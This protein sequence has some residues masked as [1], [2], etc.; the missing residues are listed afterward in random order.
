[1]HI[2]EIVSFLPP[3]GGYFAI[4]QAAALQ[5]AGNKVG[6]L[7]CQ[8]LGVTLDRM[9][10]LTARYGRWEWIAH[11]GDQDVHIHQANFRG[12]PKTIRPN[13]Q[14]YCRIIGEMFD[15]YVKKNGR[16][17]VLHAQAAK[18]AGVAAMEISKRTGIS[19]FVTEHFAKE[20]YQMDFGTNWDKDVWA[21]TLIR[22][23]YE[24]ASC[25]IPV[26]KEL[27][28]NTACFFGAD[29][30]YKEVSN[31]TDVGFYAYKERG[32]LEDRRFRF[33]CLAISNKKEFY[34]KGYDILAKAVS[35]M[36]NCELHIAGRDTGSKRFLRL[37]EEN[38]DDKIDSERI[39][40]HGDLSREEVRDLLWQCDALVLASR[41]EVQPLVVME[42]LSTGIPVVGTEVIPQSERIDGGVVISK[43]GDAESLREDMKK[44]M[45][46]KPSMAFHDK[47]ATL[48]SANRVA[49]QLM[50]IFSDGKTT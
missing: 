19:Y 4:E 25:I 42:A 49:E 47:V 35:N 28:E 39:I 17:D 26:A 31:I 24:C 15:D 27:V 45:T 2:L 16:P 5:Q 46:I 30:R 44:V 34:R 22:K 32:T 12:I 18:W 21:K 11:H 6:M 40:L 9:H 36:Q 29:Y 48:S 7:Y 38:Y 37:F 10:Y 3:Y 14:K 33:C 43:T 1:M 41:G 8:Q 13:Q 50:D 23:C 20:S